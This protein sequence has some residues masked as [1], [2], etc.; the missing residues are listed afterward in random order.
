MRV[1]SCK[2]PF[3]L[4]SY[5]SG[6]GSWYCALLGLIQ[7]NSALGCHRRAHRNASTAYLR[8]LN[9]FLKLIISYIHRKCLDNTL[10]VLGTYLHD[11]LN[12]LSALLSLNILYFFLSFCQ[13]YSL[14]L[15]LVTLQEKN[16]LIFDYY[17][18]KTFFSHSKIVFCQNPGHKAS[19]LFLLYHLPF[20]F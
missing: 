11:A 18:H 19:L 20:S 15:L 2:N 6:R 16:C 4:G 7:R 12:R 14:Y 1:F 17:L 9:I 10:D 5:L 13:S 8:H 3:E